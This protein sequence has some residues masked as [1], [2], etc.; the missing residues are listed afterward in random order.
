MIKNFKQFNSE[1]QINEVTGGGQ[2]DMIGCFKEPDKYCVMGT[3]DF[4]KYEGDNKGYYNAELDF[5]IL[6]SSKEEVDSIYQQIKDYLYNNPDFDQSV[7]FGIFYNDDKSCLIVSD[8]DY[9]FE[10]T[11]LKTV[12]QSFQGEYVRV[13]H[14]NKESIQDES[15]KVYQTIKPFFHNKW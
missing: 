10:G 2:Y 6:I 13:S 5:E 8:D 9:S 3:K 7:V 4:I 12:T 11:L 15:E 1:I 14:A